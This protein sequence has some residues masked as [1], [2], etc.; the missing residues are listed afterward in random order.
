[1]R[2]PRLSACP[3]VILAMR[4]EHWHERLHLDPVQIFMQAVQHNIEKLLTIL[5]VFRRKLFF[6]PPKDL[7]EIDRHNN[8]LIA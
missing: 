5:L 7:F 8:R 6:K 3:L 1:M 2:F 4:L